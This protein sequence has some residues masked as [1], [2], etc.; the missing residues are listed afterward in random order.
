MI[1]IPAIDIIDGKCVRLTQ[2]N[3]E[4]KKQYDADPVDMAKRFEQAGLTRL[5][6]VD[7]D[8]ARTRAVKNWKTL[9][10]IAGHC[11]LKIDF[12]GGIQTEKDLQ[13]VFDSGASFAT[14]GSMAITAKEMV[15]AWLE[16][17]GAERFL[18]G[19]D[20][21]DKKIAIHGWT[22]NTDIDVCDFINGYIATGIRLSLIHI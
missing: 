4:Q 8:G 10:Q 5:H 7:L 20:V 12:G 22:E 19:A 11:N 13:I 9:E 3:F 1:I 14:I 2:G 6:L 21:R 18:L 16:K 15:V 17:F